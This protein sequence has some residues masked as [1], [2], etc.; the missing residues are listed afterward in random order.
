MV[1]YNALL[2]FFHSLNNM[3]LSYKS[4]IAD[5]KKQN[6][7]QKQKQNKTKQEPKKKQTTL[8]M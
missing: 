2:F 8:K 3:F 4:A 7:Q 1:T 5:K 6:R